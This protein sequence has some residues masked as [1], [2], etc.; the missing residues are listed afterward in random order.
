MRES[1]VL[2][3]LSSLPRGLPSSL[4]SIEMEDLAAKVVKGERTINPDGDLL[5]KINNRWYYGD[6][7]DPGLFMQQYKDR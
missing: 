3:A 6:E 4:W 5:V 7:T 2:K 1:K